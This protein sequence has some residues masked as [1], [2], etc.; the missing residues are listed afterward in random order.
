[1]KLAEAGHCQEAYAE[2]RRAQEL[3]PDNAMILLSLVGV[4]MFCGERARARSLLREV[5]RRPDAPHV[6]V[7]LA[8][9]YTAQHQTDSA[10]AWLDRTHWGMESR[11]EL[12]VSERLQPLR[13]DP[14]YRR[15]LDRMG[16]P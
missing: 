7:Y 8:E 4:H 13:T 14:R 16:L 12:R 1:M 9:V 5:E 15:L 11:M 2:N 6:G 3:A 10:F